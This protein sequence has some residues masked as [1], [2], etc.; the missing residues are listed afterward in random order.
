MNTR[1]DGIDKAYRTRQQQTPATPSKTVD[2]I[3]KSLQKSCLDSSD[4]RKQM[5]FLFEIQI[6][7]QL[8]SV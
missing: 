6:F 8:H 5:V 4:P 7:T 3:V 2:T 1:D